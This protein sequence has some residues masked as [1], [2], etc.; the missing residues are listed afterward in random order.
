LGTISSVLEEEGIRSQLDNRIPSTNANSVADLESEEEE[1]LARIA[2][3][4][5]NGRA[6]VL[7]RQVSKKE[8]HT[9]AS[10]GTHQPLTRGEE[11]L[12][13]RKVSRQ[14]PQFTSWIEDQELNSDVEASPNDSDFLQDNVR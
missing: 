7:K 6:A 1:D 3:A 4:A 11:N 10:S 9:I 5:S 8:I 14:H 2:K 13:H 12:K